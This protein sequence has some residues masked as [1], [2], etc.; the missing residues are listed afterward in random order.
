MP[1]KRDTMDFYLGQRGKPDPPIAS[2][3]DLMEALKIEPP[4][5]PLVE[6][7]VEQDD[8]AKLAETDAPA[9]PHEKT[10]IMQALKHAFKKLVGTKE[11]QD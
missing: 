2:E 8:S 9:P 3:I 1:G 11:K 10:G 7:E 6:Q 4:E 5:K